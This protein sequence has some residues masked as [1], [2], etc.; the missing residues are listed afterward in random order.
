MT[1]AIPTIG[2]LVTPVATTLTAPSATAP[3][4]SVSV[5][6]FGTWLVSLA[7]RCTAVGASVPEVS[8]TDHADADDGSWVFAGAST[9]TVDPAGYN[10][11]PASNVSVH[12]DVAA[13][14]VGDATA[15]ESPTHSAGRNAVGSGLPSPDAM[16]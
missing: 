15:V 2:G 3:W 1:D 11:P 6:M 14:V 4:A 10:A 12:C 8:A 16:S 13:G 7:W 5:A 9:V